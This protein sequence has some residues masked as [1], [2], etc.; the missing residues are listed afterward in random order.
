[1][2]TVAKAFSC[3]YLLLVLGYSEGRNAEVARI[4]DPDV[5]CL[6]MHLFVSYDY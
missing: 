4:F 6:F 1:M 3:L 5:T 2:P